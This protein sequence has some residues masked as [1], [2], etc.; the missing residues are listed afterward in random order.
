VILNGFLSNALKFTQ[1]GAIGTTVSRPAEKAMM[2]TVF[3]TGIRMI[4]GQERITAC[5]FAHGESSMARS[6]R[7]QAL[8]CADP[9]DCFV[10]GKEGRIAH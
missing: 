10:H 6:R 2:F 5:H 3:A 8:P 4:L 7:E 1:R 9:G